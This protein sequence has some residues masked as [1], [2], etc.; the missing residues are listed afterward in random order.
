[1]AR[2]WGL[3]GLWRT[4]CS[5]E[6]GPS[7]PDTTYAVRN[8]TLYEDRNWVAGRDSSVVTAASRTAQGGIRLLVRLASNAQTMEMVMVKLADG[9]VQT[10]MSRNVDTGEYFIRDGQSVLPGGPPVVTHCR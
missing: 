2:S 1:M 9:R 5:W 6:P 7:S 3:L 8:G 4:N 10:V